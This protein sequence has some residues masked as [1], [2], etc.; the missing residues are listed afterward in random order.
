VNE[1]NRG[2]GDVASWQLIDVEPLLEAVLAIGDTHLH[3]HIL[4]LNAAPCSDVDSD[5][6][7]AQDQPS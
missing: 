6:N 3:S 1:N 2:P 7:Q 4:R 5:Q